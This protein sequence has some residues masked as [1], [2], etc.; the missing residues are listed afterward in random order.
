MSNLKVKIILKGH[1]LNWFQ[2]LKSAMVVAA[3]S[4]FLAPPRL[5]LF[6][7]LHLDLFVVP[8][9]NKDCSI[10]KLEAVDQWWKGKM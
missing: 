3:C 9:T 5:P 4:S 1:G 7:I 10:C 6:Y 2:E 8:V